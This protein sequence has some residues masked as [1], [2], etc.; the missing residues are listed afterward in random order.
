MRSPQSGHSKNSTAGAEYR[1]PWRVPV[2]VLRTLFK[3]LLPQLGQTVSLSLAI[4]FP[5]LHSSFRGNQK[6]IGFNFCFVNEL[7][8][9]VYYQTIEI[10]FFAETYR[11]AN[12]ARFYSNKYVHTRFLIE[13]RR[14]VNTGR[15]KLTSTPQ[16]NYGHMRQP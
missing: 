11:P 5:L 16:Q 15:K 9:R 1:F 7:A 10:R 13:L 12:T 3:F 8:L 6:I 2:T 14:S 4:L